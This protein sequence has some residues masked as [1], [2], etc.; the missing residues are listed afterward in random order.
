[1]SDE[2]PK[3]EP[4]PHTPP[5]PSLPT[6]NIPKP[7]LPSP[8]IRPAQNETPRMASFE[9]E[10]AP[11]EAPKPAK[12]EEE[13]T[14]VAPV[15]ETFLHKRVLAAL[16]D[17]AVAFGIGL[18]VSAI[19][20]DALNKVAW[21][22]QIAYL[23]TRDCLPFLDGQSLGKKALGLRAVTADGASLTNQWQTG[24]LRNIL[25][26]IPVIGPLV[27]LVVLYT[28]EEKPEHGLRL[29]DGFAGTKVILAPKEASAV[30]SVEEPTSSE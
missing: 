27:E 24:I 23:L 8:S 22:L 2:D 21:A 28:R 18:T 1:M 6:P 26:V 16:I 4:T 19:L 29:G 11:T 3:P 5:K 25:F 20:P 7:S 12:E 10:D 14:A 17:F 15:Q 9:A 13:M 30:A